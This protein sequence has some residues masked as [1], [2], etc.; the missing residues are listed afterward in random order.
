MEGRKMSKSLGNIIPL[1]EAVR[2]YGADALR[3]AVVST[4][5][6]LQDANFSPSLAK[7]VADFLEALCREYRVV[8]A[9]SSGYSKVDRVDRWLMSRLQR[10][11]EEVTE[12]FEELDVRRAVQLV[13]YQM[14]S[15]LNWFL[16]R[17]GCL[18]LEE[19]SYYSNTLKKFMD[20][21]ARLLAPLAPYTAE[22]VWSIIGGDGLVCKAEWPRLDPSLI[23]DEAEKGEDFIKELIEDTNRIL[24]VLPGRPSKIVYY[25][26]AGWKWEVYREVLNMEKPDVK[27]ILT[28]LEKTGVELDRAATVK[29]IRSTIDMLPKMDRDFA[30]SWVEFK[31]SH[32]FNLLEEVKGFLERE[33]KCEVLIYREDDPGVY[34]PKRR[35]VLARPCKPAIYVELEEAG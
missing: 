15:D 7:S 29:F 16:R 23:D 2:D 8:A 3:I 30:K 12:A 11:V 32:E 33:F 5:G 18:S 6:L 27:T 26:A 4:A 19:A 24:R 25:V 34:D 14:D 21:R 31:Q 22:E 1:R 35:A 17:K 10:A 13:L 28:G 20:V 9:M